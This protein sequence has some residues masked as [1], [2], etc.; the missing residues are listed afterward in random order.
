MCRETGARRV[1]R[2]GRDRVDETNVVRELGTL[3]LARRWGSGW[4]GMY[5]G[6][7]TK[8][9]KYQGGIA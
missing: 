1:R 9:D 3:A 5:F 4:D 7:G 6:G 8:T 2:L